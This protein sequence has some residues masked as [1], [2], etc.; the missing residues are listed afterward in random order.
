MTDRIAGSH[1]L[2]EPLSAER[3]GGTA[4]LTPEGESVTVDGQG[5]HEA[6]DLINEVVLLTNRLIHLIGKVV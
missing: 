3:P 2:Q 4:V 1:Q 5:G 6:E